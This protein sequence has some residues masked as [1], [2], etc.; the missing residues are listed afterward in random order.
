MSFNVRMDTEAD[1]DNRWDNRKEVVAGIIRNQRPLAFGL[2][3]CVFEQ[4]PGLWLSVAA[5]YQHCLCAGFWMPCWQAQQF[6]VKDAG[7]VAECR[8]LALHGLLAGWH[9]PHDHWPC[10][11]P[12][13]PT[14]IQQVLYNLPEPLHTMRSD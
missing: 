5:H 2:Q 1:G 6:V 9:Q 3:V 10:L 12:L 7:T 4:R 8:S 13:P 14:S 11:R